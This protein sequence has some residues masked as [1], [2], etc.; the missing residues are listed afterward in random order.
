VDLIPVNLDTQGFL[1]HKNQCILLYIFHIMGFFFK[2]TKCFL[3]WKN[4]GYVFIFKIKDV[5]F[6]NLMCRKMQ[7]QPY[8][9][10]LNIYEATSSEPTLKVTSLICNI[11][12]S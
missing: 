7:T 8:F 3:L 2:T 9:S 12:R 6:Q 11:D 5:K 10:K 4:D 1:Q